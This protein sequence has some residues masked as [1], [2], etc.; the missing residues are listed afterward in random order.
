MNSFEQKPVEENPE[1]NQGEG[2]AVVDSK[3]NSQED[4]IRAELEKEL[5][6]SGMELVPDDSN[7]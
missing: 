2:E 7:N 4:K 5:K 6:N 3:P 1:N